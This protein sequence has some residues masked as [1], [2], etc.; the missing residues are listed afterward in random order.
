MPI[1]PVTAVN[2]V[3][4][5]PF[6]WFILAYDSASELHPRATLNLTRG[7]SKYFEHRCAVGTLDIAYPSNYDSFHFTVTSTPSLI[8]KF[9]RKIHEMFDH[10]ELHRG[11]A[12]IKPTDVYHWGRFIPSNELQIRTFGVFERLESYYQMM[13]ANSKMMALAMNHYTTGIHPAGPMVA[14]IVNGIHDTVVE[15]AAM[16]GIYPS[17]FY[18]NSTLDQRRQNDEKYYDYIKNGITKMLQNIDIEAQVHKHILSVSKQI[19]NNELIRM[20][21]PSPHKPSELKMLIGFWLEMYS[22][23]DL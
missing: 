2:I 9:S 7:L 16:N 12:Y 22:K 11:I 4:E 5:T 14:D 10:T 13:S 19:S 8:V 1:T 21:S 23:R 3:D 15:S 6:C 18:K 17:P 20:T